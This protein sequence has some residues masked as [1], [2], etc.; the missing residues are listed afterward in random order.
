MKKEEII[1]AS[2]MILIIV[3]EIFIQCYTKKSIEKLTSDLKELK[4]MTLEAQKD[5]EDSEE[6][7]SNKNKESTNEKNVENM[8][9]NDEPNSEN[10]S[11][12]NKE[13]DT[14]NSDLSK[15]SQEIFKEWLKNFNVMAY[16]IEH[17]ELEKVNTQMR[18]IM[19][20]YE[21]KSLEDAVPEIEEGIFILEHIE[22]RQKITWK[23]IF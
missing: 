14:K 19:A 18:L 12:S 2:I 21:A 1:T 7:G 17:D 9:E 22:D 3:L 5:Q 11:E 10:K 8:E 20:E 16:F 6:K 23:N 15:K 13:N 4:E